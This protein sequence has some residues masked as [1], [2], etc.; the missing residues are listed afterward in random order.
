MERLFLE[1]K[2]FYNSIIASQDIFSLPD[3]HYKAKQVTV[4]VKH[5]FETRTLD[6]LSS[7]MKQEILDRTK[8]SVRG[9]SILKRKGRRIGGLKFKSRVTS[10]PLKQYGNTWKVQDRNHVRIQGVK[11]KRLGVRGLVQIPEDAETTSALLIRK[12]GDY[13]LHVTTFQ[14]QAAGASKEKQRS[15]GI[16]FGIKNQLTLSNGLVVNYAV[17][18][19]IKLKRLQRELARRKKW[20]RNWCKTRDRLEK[21]QDR[22]FNRKKDIR[23]KLIHK[24]TTTF[25]VICLQDDAIKGWQKKYGKRIMNTG[26]GGVTSALKLKAQTPIQVRRFFPSTQTCSRCHSLYRIE[27][28]ERTYCCKRCGLSIDRDLNAARNIEKEGLMTLKE[29]PTE[30]LTR[31][32]VTPADTSASTLDLAKYLNNIPRVRASAVVETGSPAVVVKPTIFSRG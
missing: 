16:D 17:Q 23:N 18:P 21:E 7:Q 19:T 14:K 31:R 25:Q 3:D 4:K 27:R 22:L 2:W 30:N 6:R 29:L 32:K 10:I 1:A 8:D 28:K 20:S 12:H 24:L 5:S 26:I 11:Q 13:Y 9:L 15:V